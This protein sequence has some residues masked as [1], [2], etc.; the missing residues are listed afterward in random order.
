MFCDRGPDGG[1]SLCFWINLVQETTVAL[2]LK[3]L[4]KEMSLTLPRIWMARVLSILLLIFPTF[5]ECVHEGRSYINGE[6]VRKNC[7]TW[8][9]SSSWCF[10]LRC[11]CG[12]R[13]DSVTIKCQSGEYYFLPSKS[14]FSVYVERI[15]GNATGLHV[16][17]R[18]TFWRRSVKAATRES[19][20]TL[21]SYEVLRREEPVC[22]LSSLIIFFAE[23]RF[24]PLAAGARRSLRNNATRN[25]R[26]C[27]TGNEQN[28]QRTI[29]YKINS[30]REFYKSKVYIHIFGFYWS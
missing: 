28:F 9:V 5:S 19:R 2:T 30:S 16:W 15:C 17:S 25:N 27:C 8:Y 14:L 29:E 23:G 12:S 20:D 3:P 6:S 11:T 21:W 10:P 24:P 4:V 7:E 22:P 13:S 18:K 26:C 1:D